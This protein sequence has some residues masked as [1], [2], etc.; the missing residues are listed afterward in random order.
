VSNASHDRIALAKAECERLSARWPDAFND[1]ARCGYTRE[2]PGER[3]KGDY[4]RGF[5]DWP[6]ERRNAWFAGFY[7]GYQERTRAK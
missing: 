2:Y 1:G 5:H 3:E 4:P 7:F 6:L